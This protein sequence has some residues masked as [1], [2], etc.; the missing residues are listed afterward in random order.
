MSRLTFHSALWSL[1]AYLLLLVSGALTAC[2][3]DET[4]Y[5]AG[6]RLTYLDPDRVVYTAPDPLSKR[7]SAVSLV[8]LPGA[9]AD[10]G[11]PIEAV[12]ARTGEA[13]ITTT[14][15]RG[16]F[17]LRVEALFEDAL[18]LRYRSDRLQVALDRPLEDTLPVT[19]SASADESQ[20]DHSGEEEGYSNG[21]KT[22]SF[23]TSYRDG[24]VTLSLV[25]LARTDGT[26]RVAY[27]ARTGESAVAESGAQSITLPALPG[28][29]LCIFELVGTIAS[30]EVCEDVSG[31]S[32]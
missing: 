29:E 32:A 22:Y 20:T 16:S 10:S 24:L 7:P 28:D 27:N 13:S 8:G 26:R 3:V 6:T 25:F 5:V 15:E 23:I 21:G 2:S 31:E 17:S 14:S 4:G 11:A 18:Q 1:P 19:I 12:N 30:V 9:V